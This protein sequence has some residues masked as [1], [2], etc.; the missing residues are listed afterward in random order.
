MLS[1]LRESGSIEQDADVIMMIFREDYYEKENP[2]GAAEVIVGKQRNGPTGT[3]ALRWDPHTGRFLNN[4]G[5]H[6]GPEPPAEVY[7][8]ENLDQ[9]PKNWAPRN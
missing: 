6:L 8:D 4:S 9:P 5:G 7:E 3:V 1:D 2:T